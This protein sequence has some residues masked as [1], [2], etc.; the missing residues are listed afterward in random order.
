MGK[1]KH[2][3]LSRSDEIKTPMVVA[4]S[5]PVTRLF[6]RGKGKLG[7]IFWKSIR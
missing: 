3:N 7:Q 6:P 5:F 1:V 4:E 2:V